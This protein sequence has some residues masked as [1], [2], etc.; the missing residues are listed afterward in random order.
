MRSK[1]AITT[2]NNNLTR[3]T[4][5]FIKLFINSHTLGDILEFDNTTDLCEDRNRKR[6]PLGNGRRPADLARRAGVVGGGR[7]SARG[8]VVAIS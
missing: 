3:E 1:V 7:R 4:R 2:F 5:N 8:S 6:V